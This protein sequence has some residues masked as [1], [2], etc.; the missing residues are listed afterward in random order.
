[1][2]QTKIISELNYWRET[3]SPLYS[4]IFTLPLFL[5]YEIGIFA[6][7]ASD[8]P[9]L[10]NGADVLMRQ[11]LEIFGIFGVYGF[12][13]TFLIGFIVAF[14]RQ[15]K[16]L[17]SSTIRGEYLL[18]MFFESIGWAIFLTIVMMWIPTYLMISTKDSR[19]LQHVVLAIGAGIYEEF[20]FRVVLITGLSH[21]IGFIFQWNELAKN[22]TAILLSAMLFSGFHFIGIYGELPSINLFIIRTLAGIVLGG[23]YVMRGFGV[24]AYTHT[25]YDLFVLVKF[26]TSS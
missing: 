1:M 11:I 14:L 7:S 21:V 16:N 18:T 2:T 3:H 4:F 19:L 23:I 15:K 12:S 25:I 20:A 8:L 10:R 24:A 22:M 9:L 6:I 26:T 13:G 17:M 5:I